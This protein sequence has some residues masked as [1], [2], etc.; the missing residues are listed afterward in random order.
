MRNPAPQSGTAA[1]E[2]DVNSAIAGIT[3]EADPQSY[4]E[5]MKSP[6]SKEW[7]IAIELEQL[8]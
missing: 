6:H 3:Y 1:T 7:E 8:K 5:A 2:H 4:H